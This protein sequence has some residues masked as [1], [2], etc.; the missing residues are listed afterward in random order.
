MVES[1]LISQRREAIKK[2]YVL[3]CWERGCVLFA[4][5]C[6]TMYINLVSD[7]VRSSK[8]LPYPALR[9]GGMV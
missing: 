1:F 5:G 8:W 4:F 3:D 6:D 9:D 7:T 2:Q